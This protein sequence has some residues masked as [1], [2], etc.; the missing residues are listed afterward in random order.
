VFHLIL[1]IN[2]SFPTISDSAVRII[3]NEWRDITCL[4]LFDCGIT[5]ESI[6]SFSQLSSLKKLN[7]ATV[8]FGDEY[9][10][11]HFKPL[12]VLQNLEVLCLSGKSVVGEFL[13][14]GHASTKTAND[15]KVWSRI[16]RIKYGP[17]SEEEFLNKNIYTSFAL[18][19]GRRNF[20]FSTWKD[21][22]T[23]D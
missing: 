2:R 21:D 15:P 6:S 17:V 3:S 22:C 13:H 11:S 14:I 16:E 9:Q 23:F 5:G 10:D 19:K 1:L 12:C 18:L 8:R 20:K 4:D 7:V